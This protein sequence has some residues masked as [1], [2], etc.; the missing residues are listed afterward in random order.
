MKHFFS[1]NRNNVVMII[2]NEICMVVKGLVGA[3]A[4]NLWAV[5]CGVNLRNL[6][7]HRQGV[8]LARRRGEAAAGQWPRVVVVPMRG[9]PMIR[10][11]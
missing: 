4:V 7:L 2:V 6:R 3:A 9:F 1:E 11:G 5:A 10:R 8:D